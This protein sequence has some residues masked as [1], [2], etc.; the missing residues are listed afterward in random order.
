MKKKV[1][2]ITGSRAEYDLLRPLIKEIKRK[3]ICNLSVAVTGSHLSKRFGY[4]LK[5]ILA[6]NIRIDHKINLLKN[7]DKEETICDA[8]GRGITKFSKILKKNNFDFII[9]LGDRFEI[10]SHVISAAFFKI[11]II[12]ISGGEISS[13][14]I[15]DCVR[16]A[17]TKFASYHFVSHKKY[18]DRV[19]QLGENPSRVFNVGSTG[20]ENIKLL[21]LMNREKLQNELN[22]P[23]RDENFLIT[24]H[25]V[26]YE[27]DYGLENFKILLKV[28]SNFKKVGLIFT[29]PNSDIGNKG[30]SN[31]IKNFV[32]NNKNSKFFISLGSN[33]YFS[34]IKNSNIVIGNSSSGLIEVP[35]FKIPTL[36]LGVRQD[37]RIRSKSVVD[38]RKIS[39]KN[40]ISSI[41]KIK[42]KK[43][44]AKLKNIKNPFEKKNTTKNI[45]KILRKIM[46]EKKREKLFYDLNR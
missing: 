17:I 20:P 10:L 5:K 15:D 37:G 45:V 14:S 24:Y 44:Q 7:G 26:T 29:M 22:F 25:P 36:N 32:K 40:I 43:F 31:L 2:V 11:P 4:T 18:R 38:C 35:S 19:I 12:H 6:D 23:L 41:N 33:K 1:C 42:S 39:K 3:K 8:M 21:N 30:F 34:C 9:V 27:K 13:G 16:H 46:K 28:L